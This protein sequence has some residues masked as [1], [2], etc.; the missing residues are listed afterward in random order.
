[1]KHL[2][3]VKVKRRF[4]KARKYLLKQLGDHYLIKASAFLVGVFCLSLGLV[5][6]ITPG[7]GLLFIFI[8]SFCI[9]LSSQR[10]ADLLD[11]IESKIQKKLKKP[12]L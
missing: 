7:P 5:M 9:A 8:G 11:K 2:L 3:K 1:M 6:V 10:F 12:K 4:Y